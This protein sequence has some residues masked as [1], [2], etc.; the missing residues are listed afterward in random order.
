M[1]STLRELKG[2]DSANLNLGSGSRGTRY[3]VP[4]TGTRYLWYQSSYPQAMY[5]TGTG[6]RYQY[7]VRYSKKYKTGLHVVEWRGSQEGGNLNFPGRLKKSPS[8]PF[9]FLLFLRDAIYLFSL[10][11]QPLPL[12][13]STVQV[14]V[15]FKNK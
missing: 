4:G 12:V 14:C 2:R 15:C 11:G 1:F 13:T 7:Q 8:F 10:D 5:S 6:L 9:Q 3:L